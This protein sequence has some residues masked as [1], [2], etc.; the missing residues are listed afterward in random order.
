MRSSQKRAMIQQIHLIWD[1]V[2]SKNAALNAAANGAVIYAATQF[3]DFNGVEMIDMDKSRED[4]MKMTDIVR[5]TEPPLKKPRN[6]SPD[7]LTIPT[8]MAKQTTSNGRGL[9]K[10][11]KRKSPIESNTA[12]SSKNND[13]ATLAKENNTAKS[14]KEK[15]AVKSVLVDASKAGHSRTVVPTIT[16]LRGVEATVAS[17]L[18]RHFVEVFAHR[19]LD[20]ACKKMLP[21]ERGYFTRLSSVPCSANEIFK[22]IFPTE[23]V[24]ANQQVAASGEDDRVNTKYLLR[25][26]TCM[27]CIL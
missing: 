16:T 12:K 10:A 4:G 15:K 2:S 18:G 26:Q 5:S 25:K 24:N 3:L 17:F 14:V 23:W 7:V 27:S 8:T 1:G 6:K 13:T 22:L 19:L 21:P 20:I 9:T 11:A